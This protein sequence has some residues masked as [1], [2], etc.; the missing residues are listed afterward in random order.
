MVSH[1]VLI[2]LT[3]I[4]MPH[5]PCGMWLLSVAKRDAVDHLREK[6]Y[7]NTRRNNAFVYASISLYHGLTQFHEA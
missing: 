1:S 5:S 6:C 2:L 4:V 3:D 7:L